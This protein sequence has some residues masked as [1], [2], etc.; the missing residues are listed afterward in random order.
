MVDRGILDNNGAFPFS[1]NV[2]R[3]LA[4][5]SSISSNS[6][7]RFIPPN[8]QPGSWDVI[9]HNGK[10][11]QEHGKSFEMLGLF[12]LSISITSNCIPRVL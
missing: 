4:L 6:D 8:F 7:K 12:L 2:A 5:A 3:V 9:C 1:G 11:P 10:E